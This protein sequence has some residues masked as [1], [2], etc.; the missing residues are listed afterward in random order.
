MLNKYLFFSF[1]QLRI[2]YLDF[3]HREVEA[4]DLRIFR[5]KILSAYFHAEML[6][7]RLSGVWK[8]W[9]CLTTL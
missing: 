8:E 4:V 2:D 3:K 6:P 1:L 7:A 9:I 5:T